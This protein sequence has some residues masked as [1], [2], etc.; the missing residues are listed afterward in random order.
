MTRNV[1]IVDDNEHLRD[2]LAAILHSS[3]YEISKAASGI[4]A[5]EKA[6]SARPH[7]ILLDLDLPDM[8]GTAVALAIRKNAMTAHIPIIGCSAFF[9]PEW[10]TEAL[11]CG[12]VDYLLKPISAA[13]IKEKIEK[14]IL[15]DR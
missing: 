1:L 15:N 5:I 6:L 2:I 13:L 12:M 4:E 10:R 7:L 11:R 14:F 9:G 8:K 3:G